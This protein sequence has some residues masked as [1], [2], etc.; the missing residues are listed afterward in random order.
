MGDTSTLHHLFIFFFFF[1][2]LVSFIFKTRRSLLYSKKMMSLQTVSSHTYSMF[3]E[4]VCSVG[5][6]I[7]K[8]NLHVGKQDRFFVL[9]MLTYKG[10]LDSYI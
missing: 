2:I 7:R 8:N 5:G 6:I 10:C 1:L 9:S 4:N 3:K